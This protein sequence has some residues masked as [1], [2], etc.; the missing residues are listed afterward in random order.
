MPK[1]FIY[2]LLGS[3]RI[4]CEDPR[5]VANLFLHRKIPGKTRIEDERIVFDLPLWNYKKTTALF[6]Q[7]GIPYRVEKREGLPF[8]FWDCRYR[9][10]LMIGILFYALLLYV[11]SEVIW[12]VKIVGLSDGGDTEV[13]EKLNEMG[14]GVGKWKKNVDP[15]GI[16]N[17]YVIENGR[18]SYM[19]INLLGNCAEVVVR[20]EKEI[21]LPE[22]EIPSSIVSEYDGLIERV[23]LY[24]GK[25]LVDSGSVVGKGQVVVSGL[26]PDEKDGTYRLVRAKAR[27][28]ARITREYTV[29]VD[30]SEEIPIEGEMPRKSVGKS[31]LFFGKRINIFKSPCLLDGQYDIIRVDRYAMLG[32]E[33]ALPFGVSDTYAVKKEKKTVSRTTAEAAAL[34]GKK[35]AEEISLSG[36][37]ILSIEKTSFEKDGRYVLVCTVYGIADVAREIPMIIPKVKQ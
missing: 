30:L 23:E 15:I 10:G 3:V 28:F 7:Y 34:A 25:L 22:N 36:T 13:L 9:F 27:V 33:I 1:P 11:S 35:L 24:S 18:F 29:T 17:R 37:E 5:R 4:S 21:L 32:K 26:L 12:S 31:L 14:L 2:G 16:A 19:A 6:V 8:L 20:P